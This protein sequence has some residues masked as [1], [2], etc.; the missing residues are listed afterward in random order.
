V[1]ENPDVLE[2]VVLERFLSADF[3]LLLQ[4]NW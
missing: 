3:A 1:E 2:Q 4:S